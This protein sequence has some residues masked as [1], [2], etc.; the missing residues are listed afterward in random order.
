LPSPYAANILLLKEHPLSGFNYA[1]P[2]SLEKAA[3]RGAGFIPEEQTPSTG[4]VKI[5]N[6][7]GFAWAVYK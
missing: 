2:T 6:D 5:T 7:V 4:T 1:L 3:W